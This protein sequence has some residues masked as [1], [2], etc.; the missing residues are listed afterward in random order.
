M[1]AQDFDQSAWKYTDGPL[2][3]LMGGGNVC[4]KVRA[5]AGKDVEVMI[6]QFVK[7]MD[8][9][10]DTPQDY[11][12]EPRPTYGATARFGGKHLDE[13]TYVVSFF[14]CKF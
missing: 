8:T 11:S 2:T 14:I 7:K 3:L 6:A 9:P 13:K 4:A 10:G 1:L 5:E 12:L